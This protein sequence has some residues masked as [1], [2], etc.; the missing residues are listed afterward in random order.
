MNENIEIWRCKGYGHESLRRIR[1]LRREY[2][3]DI[4]VRLQIIP[5]EEEPLQIGR[6]CTAGNREATVRRSKLG[7]RVGHEM[8]FDHEGGGGQDHEREQDSGSSPHENTGP[9]K[10][11]NCPQRP[12]S[13]PLDATQVRGARVGR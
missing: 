11:T 2:E 8:S 9:W 5:M 7:E 1:G 10:K 12:A 13:P 6:Q 3:G 4:R